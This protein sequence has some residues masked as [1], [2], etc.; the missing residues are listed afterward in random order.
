MKRISDYFVA[1][2]AKNSKLEGPA[3]ESPQNSD[4]ATSEPSSSG[5]NELD[6]S[7]KS[8]KKR[9]FQQKCLSDDRYK[10]W[11]IHD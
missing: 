11:L 2:T 6:L 4:L 7:A 3:I 10:S 8:Q 1:Q 5:N 9:E